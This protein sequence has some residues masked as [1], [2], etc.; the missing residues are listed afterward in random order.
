MAKPQHPHLQKKRHAADGQ[1]NVFPSHRGG[2]TTTYG[3]YVWERC[4]GHPKANHFGFVAQHR[5]VGEDLAGRP[6][7]T[8]ECVHHRNEVRTDNRPENL[9][10]LTQ[11]EHR[12]LHARDRAERA[13]IPLDPEEVKACLAKHGA[14][15]PAARELLV[16]HSTLRLRFPDLCL[17]YRRVTPTKID[18]PGDISRLLQMAT[19]GV[20][21]WREIA[22]ECHM[23]WRTARRLLER[24]GV[25]YVRP[26]RK[27]KGRPR[28]TQKV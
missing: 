18:D 12:R 3:G 5:L 26:P 9:Q 4:P 6:L 8:N 14:I 22:R 21:A 20:H 19:S 23:S 1:Y 17:P 2:D 28:S 7:H 27:D 11:T 16:S 15:K 25:A 10:V 13:A 24:H